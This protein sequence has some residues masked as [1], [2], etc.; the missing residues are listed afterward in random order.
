M[1]YFYF[2]RKILVRSKEKYYFKIALIFTRGVRM[3]LKLISSTFSVSNTLFFSNFYSFG[4]ILVRSKGQKLFQN[5]FYV[6]KRSH[7]YSAVNIFLFF[8]PSEIFLWNQKEKY[9][10]KITFTFERGVRM[11]LE[12]IYSSVPVNNTFF[13]RN[14]YFFR[15]ILFRSKGQILFQ[16]SSHV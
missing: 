2:F 16:N 8:I 1:I 11:P 15:N 5:N 3:P 10:F 4:N 9:Y 13:V 12:L 6:L 14:F 7:N